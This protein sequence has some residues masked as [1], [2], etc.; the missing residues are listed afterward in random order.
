MID[1]VYG[2]DNLADFGHVHRPPQGPAGAVRP[3]VQRV[4][5]PDE[6]GFYLLFEPDR[7]DGRQTAHDDDMD[8]YA[9]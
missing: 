3:A 7:I 6:C 1:A 2:F 4:K 5:E 8:V 9:G